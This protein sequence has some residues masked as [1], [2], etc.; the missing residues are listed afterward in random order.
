MRDVDASPLAELIRSAFAAELVGAMPDP[1]VIVGPEGRV[2]AA[3]RAALDLLPALKIDDP[4]VLALRAPDIV[5]AHRRVMAS[6]ETE[7]VQ[8]SE[9]APVERLFD[10]CIAPLAATEGGIVATLFTLRDLTE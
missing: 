5:D 2:A 3:N 6:G 8:W 7:T 1:A 10:V 9:R 4:F